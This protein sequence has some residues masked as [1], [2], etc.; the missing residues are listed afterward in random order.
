MA[1][2]TLITPSSVLEG[3]CADGS[4]ISACVTGSANAS[5]TLTRVSLLLRKLYIDTA[6][7]RIKVPL[8]PEAHP[9]FRCL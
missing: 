5:C 8:M 9:I 6:I 2:A 1:G 4:C 7:A 3:S